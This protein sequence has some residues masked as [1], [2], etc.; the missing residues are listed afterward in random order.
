MSSTVRRDR[1]RTSI[2]AVAVVA[3]IFGAGVA[4]GAASSRPAE[5]AAPKE[6][7]LDEAAARIAADA[8]RPVDKGT[9]ERAAVEGMLKALGDRWS[10]Y[11]SPSQYNSFSDALE[12]RYT[13]VGLWIRQGNDGAMLVTSVQHGS[14]AGRAGLLTGDELTSIG[15]VAVAHETVNA[16]AARLRGPS[17]STVAV[18]IRRATGI[19]TV[20]LTRSEVLADDVVVDR[21]KHSVLMIRVAT[22]S[23]GVGAQ[24]RAAMATDPAAHAGGVVLDLRDDPGGLVSEAVEVAGAFLDG[25]P[26][27]SYQQRSAGL[28][29]LDALAH[30]DT[31]T[32][33]VVLVDGSTASAAEIVTGALQDRGRAVVIGSRTYGKGSVQ[34][35]TTLSDGSAIEFT[36]GRYLTPSGRALDGVGIEPDVAID[37]SAAPSVA[38]RRALEVLAGLLAELPA[39]PGATASAGSG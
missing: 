22:F 23:L 39:P 2:G 25:G 15:G 20:T 26:V 21:L 8:A 3:V 4:V 36:V 19:L 32:P 9:L 31:T 30:G 33:L 29:T 14:P 18:G 12:G 37:P 6:G 7:V 13:G 16:V 35:P 24:V 34:E 10:A 5:G 1:L 38:E 28:T 17:G 27:V 11:Y